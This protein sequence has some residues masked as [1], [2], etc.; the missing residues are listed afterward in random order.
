MQQRQRHL[1]D[2]AAGA[3]VVFARTIPKKS[4]KTLPGYDMFC[5]KPSLR[6][7]PSTSPQH[8]PDHS[9]HDMGPS[10]IFILDH[11]LGECVGSYAPPAASQRCLFPPSVRRHHF[12]LKTSTGSVMV[13]LPAAA[14][15]NWPPDQ[16]VICHC[17]QAT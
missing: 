2:Q 14:L 6:K 7:L 5:V 12:L 17:H 1:A 13:K 4:Q 11:L 16:I 9:T 10:K 15:R 3:C 8:R